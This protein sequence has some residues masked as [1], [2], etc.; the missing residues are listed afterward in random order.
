MVRNILCLLSFLFICD[1][2]L[3]QQKDT[4]SPIDILEKIT[5][6]FF[7]KTE[8]KFYALNQKLA[9]Q[10]RKYLKR[11]QRQ[12][13]R[14]LNKLSERDS[15]FLKN[16]TI[17]S[18]NEHY[19][20]I[21]QTINS[22]EEMLQNTELLQYNSY[23][24]TLG[25]SLSFLKQYQG[26]AEKIKQPAASLNNLKSSFNETE[27]VK[28]FIEERKQQMKA[29]LPSTNVL[30][31]G[32]KKDFEKIN[33]TAWYYKAQVEEY[34]NILKDPQKI[35]ATTI[36]MLN[37]LPA[38]QSFMQQNSQLASLF[39]LPQNYGTT[40]S[41]SGLQTRSS[42]QQMIQTR[43]AAGGSGAMQQVQQN[44]SQAHAEI[45]KL[46]D[47][48]NKLGESGGD[49]DMPDFRPNSQKIKSF[50]KR[51][52]YGFDVD[53]GKNNSLMPGT[54]MIGANLGYK[55]SDK[56]VTGVGLGYNLG[57]GSIQ[58]I[59]LSHQGVNLISFLDWKPFGSGKSGFLNS[60]WISGGYEMNH[61]AGFKKIRQLQKYNV[62]QRNALLGISKKYSINKKMKGE[63]KLLYDF[64]HRD[65]VPVSRAVVWRVGY[66]L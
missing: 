51:L 49:P 15:S 34:K 11:L 4:T 16:G 33:K 42:V 5:S 61:N 58:H 10:N 50:L 55:L 63:M 38:F 17:A 22:P 8:K 20:S 14:L 21:L 30:P 36:K 32:L 1:A 39:A 53:F 64:L 40:A 13:I 2:A 9:R 23:I 24:D 62:W 29:L 25:T 66:S 19:E 48:L 26:L 37:K 27:K 12:E 28:A 47:N 59:S 52:E 45:N 3:A 60:L 65:H 31:S 56:F 7:N 43:I 35:E 57:L 54:A 44:L 6:H 18:V 41:L 46:K